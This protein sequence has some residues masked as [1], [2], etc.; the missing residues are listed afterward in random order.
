MKLVKNKISYVISYVIYLAISAL[1][2]W[3]L[4]EIGLKAKPKGIFLLIMMF[5]VILGLLDHV[6]T[7]FK[8]IR[9]GLIFLCIFP[10]IILAFGIFLTYPFL[11]S[12]YGR[13]RA[14]HL[15]FRVINILNIGYFT[16]SIISSIFL[17]YTQTKG[18]EEEIKLVEEEKQKRRIEVEKRLEKIKREKR[19]K[20]EHEKRE[21]ERI[22]REKRER[23]RKEQLEKEQKEKEQAILEKIRNMMEVSSSI[24]LDMMQD[25]LKIKRKKTKKIFF[26]DINSSGSGIPYIFLDNSL[27]FSIVSIL[28]HLEY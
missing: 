11:W 26:K 17:S 24:R 15:H 10:I 13:D 1:L 19:E 4:I 7:Y 25:V 20:L 12:L 21:K 2:I 18:K 14:Y 16:G 23:E 28:T 3:L 6:V 5:S 8:N 27:L 22:E 9:F